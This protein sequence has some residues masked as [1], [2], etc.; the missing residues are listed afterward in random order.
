[1]LMMKPMSQRER[2][3]LHL[4][5]NAKLGI[6]VIDQT[7]HVIEANQRFAD[8]LGYT[9]EEVKTLHTWDWELVTSRR[10]IE[11]VYNDLSHIDFSIETKHRRKDGSVSDVEVSGT[12]YNFGDAPSNNAILC[13]CSDISE[14]KR[15]EQALVESERRFKSYVENAADVIFTIN[16]KKEIQ[17][18][19]PNCEKILGYPP[20]ALRGDQLY[21][22]IESGSLRSF[23]TIIQLNFDNQPR[24]ACEYRI[25]N[26]YGNF[27]WYSFR[28]SNT[29]DS[30]T[31][32]PLLICLAGNINDRKENEAKL[33]YISVHD[34]LTGIYNRSFFYETMNRMSL[35]KIY[36]ISVITYDLD[37]F[38]HINDTYG[39]AEG[40]D[41]L[42]RCARVV[43]QTLRKN[44]VFA[45]TG[46]D[47]FSILLPLTSYDEA[48]MLSRR[49]IDRINEENAAT[50]G[51]KISISVGAATKTDQAEQLSSIL[52]LADFRMY[53]NKRNSS[54]PD[55]GTE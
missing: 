21:Q 39:H 31:G 55:V 42:S 4:I 46:G 29:L 19:S 12:G 51:P 52:Q 16:T 1:M 38:K 23:L 48:L 35:Q 30:V 41:V 37:H 9:L 54:R 28:F 25:K 7:H 49:M 33:E 47:E 3:I 20:D 10:D 14:R 2:N 32:E 8:M 36:P 43:G 22:Y 6:V 40:D 18:I 26:K 11:A 50:A 15:T 17:Y 53:E 24:P 5:D 45:R 13:F 27:E 44:D 34:Q